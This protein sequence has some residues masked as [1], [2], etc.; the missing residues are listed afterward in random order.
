M[1]HKIENRVKKLEENSSVGLRMIYPLGWFY[2]E[3]DCEPYWTDEPVRPYS[4]WFDD[5]KK[6]E[7]GERAYR[8]I[9]NP[10]C[11]PK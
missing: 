4:A 3:E 8:K 7:A 11:Y 1:A 5:A 9:D 10:D 6:E 2:G